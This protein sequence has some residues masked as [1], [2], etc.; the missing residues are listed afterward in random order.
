MWFSVVSHSLST[1]VPFVMK[2]LRNYIDKLKKATPDVQKQAVLDILNKNKK[3]MVGLVVSQ[4]MNGIGKDGNKLLPYQD[5]KYAILKKTLNPKGVT[6]LRLTG[7]FHKGIFANTSKLPVKF[8]STDS[9]AE[10]LIAK[11]GEL[12]LTEESKEILT[13]QHFAPAAIRWYKKLYKF[14]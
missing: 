5:K 4:L 3:V 7:K 14:R 1:L 11:Y 12:G 2:K 9:K 10:K 8:G 13:R 6:D